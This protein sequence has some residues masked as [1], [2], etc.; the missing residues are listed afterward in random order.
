MH[1]PVVKKEMIN[2]C[3][4]YHI[5]SPITYLFL[6]H[7][8]LCIKITV[9]IIIPLYSFHC[10]VNTHLLLPISMIT[11]FELECCLASS[12][13]EVRCSNVSRLNNRAPK[14]FFKSSPKIW[15]YTVPSDVIYQK[16]PSCTSVVGPR[17]RPERFL[18]SLEWVLVRV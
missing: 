13:H 12:N 10:H 1:F 11:M 7:F 8:P 17:D 6:R 2:S 15:M 18:P 14:T 16:S 3:R 4:E 9:H 5:P